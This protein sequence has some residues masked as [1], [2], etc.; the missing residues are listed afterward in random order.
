MLNKH[1]VFYRG[2][3]SL[4]NSDVK[5]KILRKKSELPPPKKT[6][7]VVLVLF[8]LFLLCET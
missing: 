5:L 7:P 8:C 6:F 3:F 1:A 2:T 4:Q